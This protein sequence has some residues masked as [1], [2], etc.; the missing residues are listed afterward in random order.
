[1]LVPGQAILEEKSWRGLPAAKVVQASYQRIRLVMSHANEL[2]RLFQSIFTALLYLVRQDAHLHGVPTSGGATNLPLHQIP[3]PFLLALYQHKPL[4]TPLSLSPKGA[5][6]SN[7]ASPLE[8]QAH[9]L[10][11][12]LGGELAP[13]CPHQ[14][15]LLC[16]SIPVSHCPPEQ[17]LDQLWGSPAVQALQHRT[18]SK[19]SWDLFL[20]TSL[21][22]LSS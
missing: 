11:Y 13:R 17:I 7:Q 14:R 16:P 6:A 22:L 5:S 15:V 18:L 3:Q 2:K 20:K 9:A 4:K 19:A 8:V 12:S 21:Q 1:M 10:L